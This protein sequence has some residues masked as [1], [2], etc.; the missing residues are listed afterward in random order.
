MPRY[1]VRLCA[2]V[3]RCSG[4]KR[5][6][7][8]RCAT[9]FHYARGWEQPMI[10]AGS[11]RRPQLWGISIAG[12]Q[13]Y[14]G[15]VCVCVCVC[16]CVGVILGGWLNNENLHSCYFF[17]FLALL[18][19]IYANLSICIYSSSR[20][21]AAPSLWVFAQ[22][23]WGGEWMRLE[24]YA[25]Q[26]YSFCER[27]P[28]SPIEDNRDCTGAHSSECTCVSFSSTTSFNL[29]TAHTLPSARLSQ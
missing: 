7:E 26:Y 13:H 15:C 10:A 1:R 16:A 22:K 3:C 17:T 14:D 29:L 4:G 25:L 20:A 21:S 24:T 8:K 6:K 18:E 19:C 23:C 9:E 2:P 11:A 28:G 5:D 27:A 12:G